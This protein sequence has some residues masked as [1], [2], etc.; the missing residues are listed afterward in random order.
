VTTSGTENPT[1]TWILTQR[2]AI[3]SAVLNGTLTSDYV[4]SG[5]IASQVW[6]TGID[7]AMSP[8]A[9]VGSWTGETDFGTNGFSYTPGAGSDR[10]ALVVV[11]AESNSNP[12]VNMNQVT[13]GGQVLTAIENADGVVVGWAGSWHNLVWLGYLDEAGIG[14][15]SGNAL[16]ITWDTAP[17]SSPIMVQASTY[18]SV[19]QS[20]VVADSASN[21]NTSAS[22]IQAGSVSVGSG[23][24]LVYVTV[25]G[26]PADHTAPVGYTEQFEQDGPVNSH[27]SASVQRNATTSSTENPTATWS[28]T[29]RLAIIS[30]VLNG[31]KTAGTTWNGLFWDETLLANTDI[32]FEVRASDTLF[33]KD[34]ASP[35]WTGVGGT[36]P[37]ISG[38][39]SGRY[40]QWRAT[41]STTDPAE[42]PVLHEVRVY[43][44]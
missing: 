20:S 18:Q 39:P 35:G 21:T 32:V 30:A 36:S 28:G 8:P 14:N 9:L 12:V 15:M 5:T 7:P 29:Q 37:V 24:R 41:L 25:C 1:A 23:D 6:D 10:I 43:Y 42:T 40:I 17:S 22:S 34:A 31:I 26:N 2:L 44:Y 19:D 11:T 16:N 13:L 4:S 27:S 33:A 3:I 38:L